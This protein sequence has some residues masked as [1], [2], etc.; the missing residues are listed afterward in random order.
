[1]ILILIILLPILLTSHRSFWCQSLVS[2]SFLLY[3]T[4]ACADAD[5]TAY[6]LIFFKLLKCRRPPP[7]LPRPTT[8][9]LYLSISFSIYNSLLNL[10]LTTSILSPT[11]SHSLY[12]KL[13]RGVRGLSIKSREIIKMKIYLTFT[14]PGP[15]W[16]NIAWNIHPPL[17]FIRIL[18]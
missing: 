13:Q 12:Y 9:S 17:N 18:Q 6:T 7:P 5:A 10:S 1:M 8:T 16:Y 4:N 2:S 3:N 14:T 15:K 11:L